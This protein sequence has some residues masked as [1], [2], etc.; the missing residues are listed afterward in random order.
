MVFG[1]NNDESI[2]KKD[3]FYYNG[4]ERIF[5]TYVPPNYDLNYENNNLIVL[6][7][8]HGDSGYDFLNYSG[9]ITFAEK[10]ENTIIVAPD[11][12]GEPK[13]WNAYHCCGI[14]FNNNEDDVGFLSMLVDYSTQIYHTKNQAAFIGHSNGAMMAH[15]MAAEAPNKVIAIADVS[16]CV[17]GRATPEGQ[18]NYIRNPNKQIPVMMIHGVLDDV[19]YYWGNNPPNGRQDV[20]FLDG[21]NL[22]KEYSDTHDLFLQEYNEENGYVHEIYISDND[23]GNVVTNYGVAV[24]L[25]SFIEGNHNWP[26]IPNYPYFI[27]EKIWNFFRKYFAI[28]ELIGLSKGQKNIASVAPNRTSLFQNELELFALNRENGL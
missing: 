1:N 26:D 21:A 13:S 4:I 25:Y 23:R 16:G 2:I 3:S 11:G 20:S 9:L 18:L 17:G 19:V 24:E 10:S 6:L 28:N 12:S 27:I 5:Y 22:W 8:G 7:H 15:K 14:A